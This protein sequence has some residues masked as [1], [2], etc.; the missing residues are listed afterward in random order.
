MV[1]VDVAIA[2]KKACF[3]GKQVHSPADGHCGAHD[4]NLCVNEKEK[5]A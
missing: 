4:N 3:L 2:F 1:G 5:Y